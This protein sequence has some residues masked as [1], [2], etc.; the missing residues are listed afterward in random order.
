VRK[1]DG[2]DEIRPLEVCEQSLGAVLTKTAT[3]ALL[4]CGY[5]T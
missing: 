1:G 5:P 2:V 3:A 4:T